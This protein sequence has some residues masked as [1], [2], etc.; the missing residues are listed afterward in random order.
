[1]LLADEPAAKPAD[2]RI[3]AADDVTGHP[4]FV[5]V[6]A[7]HA[8]LV[9]DNTLHDAYCTWTTAT[10]LGRRSPAHRSRRSD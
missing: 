6:A 7:A 5:S 1:M 10:C 3:W 8:N 9:A 4:Q 2:P